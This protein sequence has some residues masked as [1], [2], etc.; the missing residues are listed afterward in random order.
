MK[1]LIITLCLVSSFFLGQSARAQYYIAFDSLVDVSHHEVHKHNY[2]VYFSECSNELDVIITGFF[3]GYKS[4]FSSQDGRSC[5]FSPSCSLY[6]IEAIKKK[7]VFEGFLDTVDR[8]TRCNG[9]SPENYEVDMD[10]KLLID[11]P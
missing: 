7:G 3:V 5:T 9:L 6:A 2:S 1:I 10:Q 8:L 11:R 4:L